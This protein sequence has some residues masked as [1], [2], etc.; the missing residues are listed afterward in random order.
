MNM[1]TASLSF[2]NLHQHGPLF[3][4]LLRARRQS[5]I[6]EKKWDLPETL[7]MEYDQYD[8]PASR[9]LAVHEEGEVLAGLRMTPT[10]TNCG[11]YSYMIRDAQR[12]L[13]ESI[14]ADLLYEKA[15]VAE[16]I[17]EVSR[18]FLV[19]G[20]PQRI[21]RRVRLLLSKTMLETAV[22]LGANSLLVLVPAK[23]DR[24]AKHLRLDV[25][26]AGPVM[27]MGNID[28]Q[29]VSVDVSKLRH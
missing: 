24:W 13:L 23:W 15:P 12:G 8:T 6:V 5:F 22:N 3:A 10:N 4:N 14:P 28:Y 25:V 19:T 18:G 16:D 9:W 21:R 17:W 7:G 20:A 29:V 2:E 26:P 27:R 1:Q 11:I